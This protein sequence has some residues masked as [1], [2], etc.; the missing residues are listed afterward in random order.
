V[1]LD[2]PPKGG[3]GGIIRDSRSRKVKMTEGWC[4]QGGGWRG[5][6]AESTAAANEM[7]EQEVNDVVGG[8]FGGKP[9]T[10]TNKGSTIKT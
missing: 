10:I 4:R 7:E 9:L 6:Y 5:T 3:K 2:D 8:K 1:T